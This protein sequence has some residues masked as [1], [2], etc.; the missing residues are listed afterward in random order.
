MTEEIIIKNHRIGTGK[1]LV[2]VPVVEQSRE[3]ILAAAE[4]ITGKG[5]DMLEW[6]M[7]WYEQ[8]TVWE[9]TSQ[10]LKALADICKDTVLLCT[11]R[12]KKQGGEQE[13]T[14]ADYTQLLKKTAE[15]GYADILD[16]EVFEVSEPKALLAQLHKSPV[17]VIA[18]QHYFFHTPEHEVMEKE[19]TDMKAMGADIGKLAVMP[20]KNTDVLRLL[21]VT[22]SVKE[23]LKEYPIVTMAMGG[24]GVISRISGQIFGSCITFA[25][26]GKV[27]A[28]GQLAYE[29][30]AMILD[31]ISESME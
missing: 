11:F 1:P 26:V 31:K 23:H 29:D 17:Y 19:L 4:K 7:D 10:V 5:V 21:K 6:R 2:C 18:S 20:E 30:A 27:S 16:V 28:P 13:M 12:S 15:S 25:A 14:E 9:Q 3:D 24:M 22:A 8:I